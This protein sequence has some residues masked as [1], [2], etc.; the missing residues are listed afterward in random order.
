MK[1][2]SIKLLSA[3]ALLSVQT[4]ASAG[5]VD[6]PYVVWMNL[7][8]SPDA[9]DQRIRQFVNSGKA[10]CW[11]SEAVLFMRD[12][13][14][15]ITPA[16]VTRALIDS[17]KAAIKEVNKLL[18]RG[19]GEMATGGFDGV[20]VYTDQPKPAVYSLTTG[21]RK[22]V[23][24]SLAQAKDLETSFCKVLPMITRAP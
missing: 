1:M 15:T 24:V 22:V 12:K 11:N 3:C 10:E 18:K 23:Q 19:H 7:S 16:L 5:S 9:A 2:K 13:P 8:G 17:D 21:E 6:G 14:K 4:L 20:V